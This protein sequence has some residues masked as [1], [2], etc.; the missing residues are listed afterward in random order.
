MDS[1]LD[2]LRFRTGKLISLVL[3]PVLTIAQI[4]TL[5]ITLPPLFGIKAR[6]KP[7]GTDKG[8]KATEVGKAT[9]AAAGDGK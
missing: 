7:T 8:G 3:I 4:G 2:C 5:I 1:G 6:D 9:E